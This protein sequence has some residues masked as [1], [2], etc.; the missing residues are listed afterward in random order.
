MVWRNILFLFRMVVMIIRL[1]ETVYVMCKGFREW[2]FIFI[3]DQVSAFSN[4]A[5]DVIQ[6]RHYDHSEDGSQEHTAKCRRTDGTITNSTGTMRVNQW[7]Q[8]C[9]ERE[10]CHQDRTETH[11]CSFDRSFENR[12]TLSLLLNCKLNNQYRILSE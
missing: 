12:C 3:A 10:G 8:P 6:A 4:A 11:A 7:N 1:R 2:I 5:E 9:N